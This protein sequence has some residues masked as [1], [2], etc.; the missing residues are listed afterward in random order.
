MG[1][2][3]SWFILCFLNYLQNDLSHKKVQTRSLCLWSLTF[4]N[5]LSAVNGYEGSMKIMRQCL[6]F[7][8]FNGNRPATVC[9]FCALVRTGSRACMED[10]CRFQTTWETACL[11]KCHCDGVF[12][13]WEGNIQWQTGQWPHPSEMNPAGRGPSPGTQLLNHTQSVY[14]H[15][16][17]RVIGRLLH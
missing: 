17:N 5:L 16:H 11:F 3:L 8:V 14:I 7:W 4:I 1:F 9:V 15:F 13:E 12:E 10:I 2:T 6:C